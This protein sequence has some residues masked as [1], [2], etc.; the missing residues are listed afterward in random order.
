MTVE[1]LRKSEEKFD[2][3][4]NEIEKLKRIVVAF[5]GGVDS[6]FLLKV[7]H[8]CIGDHV[9]ALTV[10]APYIAD[11]E[12]EE[13]IEL[14]KS[15]G[16]PHEFLNVGIIEAI[17]DNPEN[18]CYL[19]KSAIFSSIKAFAE[20][21]HYAYVADGSNADDVKDYRPGMKALEELSI[22]SPLLK[23]GITKT[24]I[25][26]WSKILGLPTWDKPPYACLLTRLPYDTMVTIEDLQ[27]IEAAETFIIESGIRAV[28][29]RKHDGIA[30]VEIDLNEMH[31]ILEPEKL[32][33]VDTRLKEIGFKFVT[34]D[35]AGYTM[36]SF[37]RGE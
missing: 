31:K 30:R 19:C 9:M 20:N 22:K 4:C 13:A 7:A 36:G 17:K 32:K 2:L 33:V 23:S 12:V 11:W 15:L 26:S 1:M 14:T 27:M 6:T 25:R 16:I 8:A 18:R 3:L 37:N 34:L 24:E 35:M 29:V 10:N 28:R 21:N 5:S